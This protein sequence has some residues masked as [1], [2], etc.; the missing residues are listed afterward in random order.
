VAVNNSIKVGPLVFLFY[1]YIYII[2]YILVAKGLGCCAKT[3]SF[4]T[5][6][7]GW[8]FTCY[9]TVAGRSRTTLLTVRISRPAIS[10]SH[11]ATGWQVISS[12][13]LYPGDE[14]LCSVI[15][16]LDECHSLANVLV[17]IEIP[18]LIVGNLSRLFNAEVLALTTRVYP[19]IVVHGGLLQFIKVTNSGRYWKRT[20][21]K[22][23]SGR[24]FCPEML[25]TL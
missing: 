4:C 24:Y 8:L 25:T 16:R 1:I 13:L 18:D 19:Y 21:Q 14:A 7:P 2:L 9:G 5:I 15:T 10:I 23:K 11:E 22:T 3:S 20:V 17:T 12:S 6:K